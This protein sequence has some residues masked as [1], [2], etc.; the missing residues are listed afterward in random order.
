MNYQTDLN[1]TGRGLLALP[2]HKLLAAF[3]VAVSLAIGMGSVW[4]QQAPPEQSEVATVNI[5]TADAQALAAGLNGVGAARAEDIVR[6]REQFGPF[7]TP[8]QLTEVKGIGMS[9]VDKNRTVITLD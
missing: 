8:E 3:L 2:L 7:T 6:F 9:T 1:E 4:A 5:N